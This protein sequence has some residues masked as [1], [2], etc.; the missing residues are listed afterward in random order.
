MK[1]N[2]FNLGMESTNTY[3]VTQTYQKKAIGSYVGN[4]ANMPGSFAGL[5]DRD[6]NNQKDG[7]TSEKGEEAESQLSGNAA[8]VDEILSMMS[9]GRP[10]SRISKS[11]RITESDPLRAI[12]EFRQ[13]II[14]YLEELFNKDKKYQSTKDA[15][16]ATE[17]VDCSTEVQPANQITLLYEENYSYT[18]YEAY[19]FST[20]GTVVDSTGRE[21]QFNLDVSMSR[22]FYAEYGQ[23]FAQNV[24]FCDPLVINLDSEV[25]EISDQKFFFDL[26]CD[27]VKDEIHAFGPGTG[28]LALDLNEDGVINDGGELFGTKTGDGFY[29]LSK[30]DS[31]RNGWIDENDEIWNKVK[32]WIKEA[33]GT[34]TLYSLADKGVGAIYLGRAGTN[35]HYKDDD[36]LDT[37]RLRS[38]G[39]FLY[40]SGVAGTMQQVDLAG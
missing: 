26:D 14:R 2:S 8:S 20:A 25:A 13:H 17:C 10:I 27:G 39:M 37:A 30:Y 16:N 9:S 3:A 22:T 36:N 1:I 34:D 5:F 15:W 7:E 19:S 21:I 24:N 35:F 31:D 33:D 29:D 4:G 28:M 38:T 12:D 40:E 11:D 6:V 18:E 32:I 23:T